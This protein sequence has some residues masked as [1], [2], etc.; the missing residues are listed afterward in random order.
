MLICSVEE[1]I[2]WDAYHSTKNS[3]AVKLFKKKM[4]IIAELKQQFSLPNNLT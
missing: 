1:V 2:P 3:G 4:I